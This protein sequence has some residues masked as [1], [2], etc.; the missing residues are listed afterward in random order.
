MK[1]FLQ[2]SSTRSSVIRID[3]R[4][5]LF[6]ILVGNLAVFF[7]PSLNYEILLAL[8]ILV[9]GILNGVYSFSFKMITAYFIL[10]TFQMVSVLYLAGIIK[11]M[12]IMFAVVARKMLP[13][14]MLGGILISTT[15]VNEF[16]A[17]MNKIHMPKSIVIPLTVMLRYFPIVGEEWRYIKDA[18]KMRDVSPS[19][20]GFI[21][22]P[23]RT[24]ECIYVPMMMSASKI[25]DELSVASIT[26][27]IE[28]P[29]P[30][31]CLQQIN[32]CYMDIVCA[33][34]FSLVLL[35]SF[36]L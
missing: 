19:F 23:R 13:C 11:S 31:T 32:F 14:C 22:N 18:M 5:K 20:A 4:T 25:A 17:A 29:K 28:N 7:S 9:F 2:T 26:R 21:I 30:R 34:A 6:I 24:L 10:L 1:L 16:M 3:P 27:G 33:F 12:F 36:V 8:A 35:L 15:R